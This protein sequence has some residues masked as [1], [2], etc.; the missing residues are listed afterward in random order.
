MNQMDEL[1]R[2]RLEMQREEAK[3]QLANHEAEIDA[4]KEHCA[5]LEPPVSDL[6]V[7]YLETIGLVAQSPGLWLALNP[8]LK[9]DKDGLYDLVQL[10]KLFKPAPFPGTGLLIASDFMLMAHSF[11]R[12]AMHHG[13]NWESR[14]IELFWKVNI[15]DARIF[16]AL[17]LDRVRL[18]LKGFG[19]IELDTWHGAKFSKNIAEVKDGLSQLRPPGD[20]NPDD[21]QFFFASA[22][23]LNIKWSTKGSVKTFQ[24]EAYLQDNVLFEWQD[25]IWHPVRYV[26]AQYDLD[27]SRFVHFD[28]AIHFY[29]PADYT[30]MRDQDLDYN[31][32]HAEQIKAPAIKLFKMDDHVPLETWLELTSQFFAHNPL[33]IEYFEGKYPDHLQE[34]LNIIRKSSN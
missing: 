17:D 6:Q 15:P 11:F 18:D 8:E 16:V 3:R 19:Y 13:A 23:S 2:K 28:G 10:R 22:Y 4:F 9:P 29:Q 21:L 33:I 24:A 14:F 27:K 32:K 31:F 12:R 30:V 1:R 7:H 26:H 5:S 20:I 25:D 34:T